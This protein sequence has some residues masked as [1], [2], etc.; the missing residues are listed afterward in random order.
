MRADLELCET[1]AHAGQPPLPCPILALGGAADRW[2]PES[3]LEGWRAHAGDTLRVAQL[4]G[5]HFY[6][7]ASQGALLALLSAWQHAHILILPDAWLWA[8]AIATNYWII[9]RLV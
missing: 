6:L 1:Y 7:Q 4:P 8:A 5:D 9:T 2:V 3:E